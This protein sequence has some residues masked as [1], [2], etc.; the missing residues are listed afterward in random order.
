MKN[1]YFYTDNDDKKQTEIQ[2]SETE[3]EIKPEFTEGEIIM[4][5]DGISQIT[6]DYTPATKYTGKFL[7]DNTNVMTVGIGVDTKKTVEYKN[8]DI[9]SV[10]FIKSKSLLSFNAKIKNIRKADLSDK[11]DIDD[12]TSELNSLSKYDKYILDVLPLT[13]PEHQQ[14]R[15][16]FRMAMSIDVYYKITEAEEVD[17]IICSELK[18]DPEKANETKKAADSGIL[19]K[20]R[21]YTKLTT[22]DVSAGGFKYYSKDKVKDG[23]FYKCIII[24]NSEALPAV[25]QVINST[26]DE[27]YPDLYDVRVLYHGISDSVRDRVIRYIF[28]KQRQTRSKVFGRIF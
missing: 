27:D 14:R 10:W 8:D 1:P 9:I 17:N 12:I 21:G 7:Y 6:H 3:T 25:A 20:E 26:L 2:A 28:A 16:F 11:F 4:V 23:I 13:E 19:E 18:F 5:A 15:E 24:I 22:V